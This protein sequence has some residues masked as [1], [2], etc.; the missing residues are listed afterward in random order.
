[1]RGADDHRT[2]DS[3]LWH[4]RFTGESGYPVSAVELLDVLAQD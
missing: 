3:R 4:A 2:L 1:V